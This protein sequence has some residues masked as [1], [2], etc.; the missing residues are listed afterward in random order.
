MNKFPFFSR[1]SLYLPTRTRR[2]RPCSEG[3]TP[4]TLKTDMKKNIFTFAAVVACGF[5]FAQNPIFKLSD[6]DL[7][8]GYQQYGVPEKNLSVTGEAIK[9]AGE[10]FPECIGTHSESLFRVTTGRKA[11]KFTARVG[12]ADTGIDFASPALTNTVMTS[13]GRIL[14]S[15]DGDKKQFAGVEFGGKVAPGSA[16]F[17]VM[18]DGKEVY[19]SP[20][21]RG[22]DKAIEVE[23][24]LKGVS[25]V[26]L[27]VTDAGDG[28]SGDRA[29]W[30]APRIEY[31]GETAPRM[32]ASDYAGQVEE[33]P[34]AV[35]GNLKKKIAGLPQISLP[36]DKPATDWLLDPAPYTAGIYQANGGKDI[37]ISN[38]LTARIFR[39]TP[40]LATMDYINLML[41]ETMIRA[42]SSE[43]EVTID[44][45]AY[46]LGGLSGQFEYGYTKYDWVDSLTV[47]PNS[48]RV[49]DFETGPLQKNIDWANK[50]WSPIKNKEVT[51][52]MITFTLQGPGALSGVKAKVHFAIYDGLPCI[53][54]W[55]D[56]E[57]TSALPINIDNFKIEKLAMV[58]HESPVNERTPN[59]DK[60]IKYNIHVESNWGLLGFTERESDKAEYWEIDP[61]FSSQCNWAR[62]TPC[63]LEVR[64]PIGPD[65]MLRQG[66]SL[67]TLR[68]WEMPFDSYDRERKGMFQ[69]RMYKKIS[70][71]VTENPIFLHCTSSDPAIVREAIDQ[72]VA[73]GYEMVILSFGSG[74]DMEN[75][76][77]QYI[78]G[79][80]E[81]VDYA[82]SKGIE[83]GGYS[84]LA[85][86]WVSDEVDVINPATGKRGDMIF[87]SSP[88]LCSEWGYEYFR[89]IKSFFEKTGMTVFEND[90]SYPGDVCAST[91]HKHHRGLGDSQ[92]LQKLKM[93]SLYRWMCENGIYTNVP[94]YY[95]L[96]GSNKVGIGYREDNWSLPRERQLVLGR[97]IIYDGLWERLPSMCWTFVP[98]VEYHGGGAA[99][100]L[101]PLNDHLDAYVGH[102]MQNYGS[103][104]QACYRGHRL[105][106]T[107]KTKAAVIEVVDWYKKYR[108]ILNSELIHIRRADGKDYDAMMHVNPFIGEKG[109]VMVYNPTGSD[110]TRKIELPMY[111]TGL[112]DT[113]TVREKEGKS[114]KYK[115]SRD[116]KIEVEVTI[117]ANSYTWLVVE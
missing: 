10:N 41:G 71:W 21:V 115:V 18:A 110:M 33:L 79:I 55:I 2:E 88:C 114:A 51:G 11:V 13:G 113:A 49:I 70:P 101:E 40:N 62:Q 19:T 107:D 37:V 67:T 54:K 100:T 85:S 32:V 87:G 84:L 98:L 74:L 14:Y 92:W 47:T 77:P 52:K 104:I 15:M 81:L 91:T 3:A 43:G 102:M 95:V 25:V 73:T 22:G 42:V 7:K 20:V 65:V 24:D 34:A 69:R 1:L 108:D 61:N 94:D 80:K 58:E 9:V 16:V 90:G 106:D 72:C 116:Y 86:R 78:A 82:R 105:Y 23:I 99:A 63:I 39:I 31:T 45:V 89:K 56:F 36:L 44:S 111:Y 8:S 46:P 66:E 75:E 5:S 97:Q 60:Y 29:V 28:A 30:I 12:I 4:N 117:P 96:C 38:G 48:F 53:S 57:N 83:L 109:F 59:P 27:T 103:G 26:D 64:L 93:D 50:R 6:A 76:D 112:H 17:H 68:T 35:A